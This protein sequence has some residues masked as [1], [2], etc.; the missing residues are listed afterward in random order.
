MGKNNRKTAQRKKEEKQAKVVIRTV[1][2][3]LLI[4]AILMIVGFSFY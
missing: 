4:L 3:S 2:I 1:F